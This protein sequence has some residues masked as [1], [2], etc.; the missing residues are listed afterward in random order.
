MRY[1]LVTVVLLAG[2]MGQQRLVEQRGYPD[3]LERG[4]TLNVQVARDVTEIEITNTTADAFGPST[5]WLNMWYH[6]DIDGFA[7]GQT[8]RFSLSEFKDEFGDHFR[9]G[10]FFATREPERLVLAE[11]E[12]A[13]PTGTRLLRMVVVGQAEAQP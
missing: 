8:L 10:G 6:R 2:C 5:I 3:H 1:L 9:G 4:R 13:Q 7:P 12:T 11:L